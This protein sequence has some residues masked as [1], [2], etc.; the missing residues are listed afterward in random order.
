MCVCKV[1]LRSAVYQESLR[2]F[3]RTDNNNNNNK[4]KKNNQSNVL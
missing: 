3:W 2:D 1:S 4:N